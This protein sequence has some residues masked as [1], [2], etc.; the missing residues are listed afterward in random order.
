M[1]AE[2]RQPPSSSHPIGV[3][4]KPRPSNNLQV[5]NGRRFSMTRSLL[6][7]ASHSDLCKKNRLELLFRFDLS[8]GLMGDKSS[9]V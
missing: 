7:A 9:S 1:E 2:R 8:T 5:E 3:L 6:A 4:E